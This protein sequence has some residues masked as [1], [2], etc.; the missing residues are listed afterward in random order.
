MLANQLRQ[1]ASSSSSTAAAGDA[2]AAVEEAKGL[3]VPSDEN[4]VGLTPAEVAAARAE[5]I[6]MQ[7]RGID[8]PSRCD[9]NTPSRHNIDMIPTHP[10]AMQARGINTPSR[11]PIGVMLIDSNKPYYTNTLDYT[12]PPYLRDINTS[13]ADTAT[14]CRNLSVNVILTHH[15]DM[16]LTH[17][18]ILTQPINSPILLLY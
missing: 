3:A 7:A 9:N 13:L 15:L 4:S 6:A 11:Y 18:V 1:Q 5:E 12:N 17:P 8:T 2:G 14:R 16:I 10:I